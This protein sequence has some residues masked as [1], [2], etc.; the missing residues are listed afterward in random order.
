MYR[1]P[2]LT[3]ILVSVTIATAADTTCKTEETMY[4]KGFKGTELAKCMDLHNT[5]VS[6]SCQVTLKHDKSN[7]A[8]NEDPLKNASP[9]DKA[10][11]IF[12]PTK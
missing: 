7:T 6:E 10:N 12:N 1:Y 9:L 3:A 5:E 11:A 2:L 8:K 4:C